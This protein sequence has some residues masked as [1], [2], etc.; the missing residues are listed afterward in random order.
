MDV[1]VDPL[2]VAHLLPDGSGSNPLLPEARSRERPHSGARNSTLGKRARERPVTPPPPTSQRRHKPASSRRHATD[3]RTG[4]EPESDTDDGDVLRTSDEDDDS[5][6]PGAKRSKRAVA[7]ESDVEIEDKRAEPLAAPP[8]NKRGRPHFGE[9]RDYINDDDTDDDGGDES[10]NDESCSA[11]SLFEGRWPKANKEDMWCYMR[12]GF[13]TRRDE[14]GNPVLEH[15]YFLQSQYGFRGEFRPVRAIYCWYKDKLRKQGGRRW[16]M[17]SIR[18]WCRDTATIEQMT[19]LNLHL[20][21][22]KIHLL[23]DGKLCRRNKVTG[24]VVDVPD[25]DKR[26][27]DWIKTFALLTGKKGRN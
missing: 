23:A 13:R 6:E 18:Q 14:T 5:D 3:L 22:T 1:G 16:T 20:V 21:Q 17:N 24:R 10:D 19:A 4:S 11:G 27:Q 15:I 9:A 12:D 7:S 25:S 8:E 2:P 26:M